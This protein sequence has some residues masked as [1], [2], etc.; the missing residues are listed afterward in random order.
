MSQ[1]NMQG[2]IFEVRS[3]LTDTTVHVAYATGN[4]V[5]IKRYYADR[6]GY[7]LTLKPVNVVHISPQMANTKEN[8]LKEKQEIEERLKSINFLL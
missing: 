8:L 7:E 2:S 3:T 4:P 1:I 5:D 6:K